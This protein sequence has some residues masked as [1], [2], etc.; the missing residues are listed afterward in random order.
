MRRLLL[1]LLMVLTLSSPAM[2]QSPHDESLLAHQ[3]G[4]AAVTEGFDRYDTSGLD[5]DL[6]LI[7]QAI[8]QALDALDAIGPQDCDAAWWADARSVYE[9]L[10]LGMAAHRMGNPEVTT[11]A[12]TAAGYLMRIAEIEGLK[13]NCP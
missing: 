7:E 5:L 8:Q 10:A 1:S 3:V 6:Q 11:T 12:L 13:V 2:A 9:L 4:L